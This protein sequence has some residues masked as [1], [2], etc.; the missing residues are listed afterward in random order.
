M[1]TMQ[2]VDTDFDFDEWVKLAKEDPDAFESKR[3]QAIQEIL[4]DTSPEIK[5]RMEGIQWQIDQICSTSSNPMSSCLKISQMMWGNVLGENGLVEH[6]HR[7][8][9]P[10]LVNTIKPKELATVTNIRTNGNNTKS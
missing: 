10:E 7:L 1:T 8:N 3:K 2:S 6:M 9:S 5:R 4:D